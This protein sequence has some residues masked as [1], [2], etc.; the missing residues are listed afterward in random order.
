MDACFK[1]CLPR[2]IK[3]KSVLIH[4]WIKVICK[5]WGTPE[6]KQKLINVPRSRIS[7]PIPYELLNNR[8]NPFNSL[9]TFAEISVI[10]SAEL[11]DPML[12][13]FSFLWQ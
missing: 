6:S 11:R 8:I 1:V 13:R 3:T 9:I 12:S 2:T 4:Y 10:H 5:L 7:P